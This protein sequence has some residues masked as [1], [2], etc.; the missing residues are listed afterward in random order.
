MGDGRLRAVGF[1]G[2]GAIP[3]TL[4]PVLEALGAE[5]VH[6]RRT[7]GAAGWLPLDELLS[8]SDVISLHL[9][10]T[11]ETV[12]LIDHARL[13]RCKQGA[14][15]IN[16]GRG[17]VVDESALADALRRGHLSGAGLDVFEREPTPATSELL[18]LDN[19]V[20]T[21]HVAWLTDETFGRCFDRGFENALRVREGLDPLHRVV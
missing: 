17:E 1:V 5:I 12:H 8:T 20:L 6:H 21:P 18:G 11:P 13:A 14:V 3:Q 16:T 10:A 7:S 19:V 2:F 4:A 9:P 15:L